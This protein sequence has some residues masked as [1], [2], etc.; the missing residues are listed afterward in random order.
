LLARNKTL[1]GGRDSPLKGSHGD[2]RYTFEA[3]LHLL[4]LDDTILVEEAPAEPQEET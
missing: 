3:I 1:F 2:V 4:A